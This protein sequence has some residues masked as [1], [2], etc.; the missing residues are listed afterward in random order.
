VK[1][2]DEMTKRT[3]AITEAGAATEQQMHDTEAPWPKSAADLA[4]YVDTLVNRPHDYGTC[5]YAMSLA[6][7][8]AFNYVGHALGTT[9]FQATCADLD[10]LR[11][12]RG[13]KHGFMIVDP[14][15]LLYPQY[16]PLEDVMKFLGEKKKKE[17]REVAQKK[18]QESGD[19]AHPDVVKHWKKMAVGK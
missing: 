2:T 18:L 9:G 7:V 16:D 13:Y 3:Q 5:S 17:L 14:E 1:A 19:V 10:F 4:A 11:R 8:A 6:A 15:N 12:T